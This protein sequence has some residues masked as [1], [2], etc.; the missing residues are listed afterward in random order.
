MGSHSCPIRES[1]PSP[2]SALPHLIYDVI[3][4]QAYQL[5]RLA[6]G[7]LDQAMKAYLS[8]LRVGSVTERT[9]RIH[10]VLTYRYQAIAANSEFFRFSPL[11]T[12]QAEALT[13]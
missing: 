3:I 10:V 7:S 6:A 5:V 8:D 11:W 12:P 2:V 4:R 9:K 1:D 13:I